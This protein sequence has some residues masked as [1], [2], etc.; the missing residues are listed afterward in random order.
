M[1]HNSKHHIVPR[2]R[3][4]RRTV[5]LEENF[6]QSFHAI[7]GNLKPEEQ[8]RFIKIL[9]RRMKT[10]LPIKNGELECLRKKAKKKEG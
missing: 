9:T 6:H 10:Q 2:S 8:I 7:F 1:K 4:G 3:G 5:E